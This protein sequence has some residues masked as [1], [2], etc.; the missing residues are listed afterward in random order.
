MKPLD[1]VAIAV[2]GVCLVGGVVVITWMLE[3]TVEKMLNQVG[4]I[5]NPSPP[6]SPTTTSV[7]SE[8][9]FDTELP[10]EHWGTV[11]PPPEPISRPTE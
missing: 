2:F 5:L 3:K 11:E 9:L 6:V 7:G 8:R 10:W 4:Q 1:V